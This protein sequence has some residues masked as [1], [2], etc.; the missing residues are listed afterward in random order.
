MA[1]PGYRCRFGGREMP[2]PYAG[3]RRHKLT[4]A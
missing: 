4:A 1:I 3:N 2:M